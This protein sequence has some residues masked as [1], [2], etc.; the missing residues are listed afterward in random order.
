VWFVINGSAV[1]CAAC[2]GGFFEDGTQEP[3]EI[4]RDDFGEVVGFRFTSP[5]FEVNPGETSR[6][7]LIQTN[8]TV[9]QPGFV[10]VINSGTA[11][12][13]AFEP[14]DPANIPE[15]ASLVLVGIGLVG[16]AAARW[17]KRKA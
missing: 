7:L 3:F 11:T 2:P 13:D 16:T 4:D 10:S 17:Q 14:T 6:V 8:A 9:Y 1:P 15:P 12:L 5:G